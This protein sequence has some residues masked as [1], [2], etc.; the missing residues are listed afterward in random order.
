MTDNLPPLPPFAPEFQPRWPNDPGGYTA[1]QMQAYA[2]AAIE[3]DRERQSVPAGLQNI[4]RSVIEQALEWVGLNIPVTA[5]EQYIMEQTGAPLKDI[6]NKHAQQLEQV[7]AE[8][9]EMRQVVE[10]INDVAK[11][12][13]DINIEAV[14]DT[15]T[16]QQ[17]QFQLLADLAKVYGPQEVPFDSLVELSGMRNKKQFLDQR[18]NGQNQTGQVAAK[19]AQLQ[20]AK[21]MADI[22]NKH[23]DTA[24]KQAQ[25]MKTTADAQTSQLEGVL[26]QS[27][28]DVTPNV[29]I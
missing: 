20:Q 8:Q 5:A 13:V 22:E 4:D 28:P 23:A 11:M 15:L 17:E 19:A 24:V 16:L 27:I 10:T 14:P 18:R 2:R 3:K 25:A 6:K 7:Y 29:I 12:D 9:P 1:E 21:A 26:L